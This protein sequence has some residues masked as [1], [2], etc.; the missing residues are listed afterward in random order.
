[1][2]RLRMPVGRWGAETALQIISKYFEVSRNSHEQL[3]FAPPTRTNATRFSFIVM[4]TPSNTVPL[5]KAQT[6]EK[7]LSHIGP[8]LPKQFKK[9]SPSS[10]P[11]WFL[12]FLT[13]PDSS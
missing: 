10:W 8:L 9:V 7:A 4:P 12:L 2:R 5:S 6:A 3:L 13:L 11:S 1:M